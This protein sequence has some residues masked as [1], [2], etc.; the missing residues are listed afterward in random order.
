MITKRKFLI[1][2]ASLTS[3]SIGGCGKTETVNKL[4][5]VYQC[6]TVDNT[7]I[8]FNDDSALCRF[9]LVS[10]QVSRYT[11]IL[12]GTIE[13]VRSQTTVRDSQGSI[14][15]ILPQADNNDV[16]YKFGS[17]CQDD[18]C[19]INANP[20]AYKIPVGNNVIR[21][22]GIVNVNSETVDLSRAVPAVVIDVLYMNCSVYLKKSLG[23]LM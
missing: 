4:R 1:R 9:E 20:T 14:R 5:I 7:L 2:A 11:N 17:G 22:S 13:R 23:L 19:T 8:E 18:N 6:N 15:W 21:V 16:V 10:A 3:Y 12:G